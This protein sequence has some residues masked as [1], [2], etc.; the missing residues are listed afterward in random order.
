L[1]QKSPVVPGLVNQTDGFNLFGFIQSYAG[2]LLVEV[3]GAA[4]AGDEVD[5]SLLSAL[6][7]DFSSEE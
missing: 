4:G 3:A 6:G 5:F 1:E 2:S 7:V